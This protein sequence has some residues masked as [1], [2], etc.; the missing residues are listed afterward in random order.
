MA[1]KVEDA[2]EQINIL[3]I[4][5]KRVRFN[6]VFENL[7]MHR[8]ATKAVRE[9]MYPA[10]RTS[11][12]ERE[13]T[14]KHDPIAE[15]RECFYRNSDPKRPALFH[16]PAGMIKKAM[17]AAALEMPDA[18]KSAILRLT[19]VVD[20]NIDLFGI[21]Y[22][23]TRMC[24][25]TG[26]AKTP[27]PRTRPIFPEAACTV[28][29]QFVASRLTEKSVINLAAAAGVI[30]GVGDGRGEGWGRF[31]L[32]SDDNKDFRRIVSEQGRKPQLIA[33]EKPNFL[34]DET[35]ELITW[36]QEEVQ[37]REQGELLADD[38]A[39]AAE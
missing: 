2:S 7:V 8:F 22:L 16:L 6:L 26:P 9:L 18:T 23:F 13:Q 15:Y 1:K 17:G 31:R 4:K 3:E 29:I 36:F 30:I 33:Y 24:R 21:P 39:E 20:L 37:R 11:R 34:D 27:D 35:A 25:L 14:L 28:T 19:N 32:V 38:F 10:R 5:T 12:V